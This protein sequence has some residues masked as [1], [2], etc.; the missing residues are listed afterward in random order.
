[1]L[2]GTGQHSWDMTTSSSTTRIPRVMYKTVGTHSILAYEIGLLEGGIKCS[3]LV[4]LLRELVYLGHLEQRGGDLSHMGH[5]TGTFNFF[6]RRVKG[7]MGLWDSVTRLLGEKACMLG[8]TYCNIRALELVKRKRGR[9]LARP[10]PPHPEGPPLS[11]SR[12]ARRISNKPYQLLEALVT[13]MM[14][15]H[16]PHDEMSMKFKRTILHVVLQYTVLTSVTIKRFIWEVFH[17]LR[18]TPR[19]PDTNKCTWHIITHA[20]PLV[21]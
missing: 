19:Q 13:R 16:I 11:T 14:Q 10:L 20:S 18:V 1:M 2:Q 7:M 8:R 15:F 12:L 21:A 17:V 9:S 5:G 4:M 3:M 6:T